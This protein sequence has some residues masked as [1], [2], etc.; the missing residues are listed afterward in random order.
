MNKECLKKFKKPMMN[1]EW[2][3][4]PLRNYVQEILPYFAQE[5]IGSYH[6]GLVNGYAQFNEPWEFLRSKVKEM[7]L[8]IEAWQHDIFRSDHTPYDTKEI[9]VFHAYAPR[10]VKAKL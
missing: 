10:S 6:W 9:E 1:T 5:H 2:L 4:R 8:D 3:H 7:N